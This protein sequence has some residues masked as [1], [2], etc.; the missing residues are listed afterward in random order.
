MLAANLE[1]RQIGEQFKL[2]DTASMPQRPY[3]QTQRLGIMSSGAIAGLILGL[4]VVGLGE[5]RDS[6]FRSEQE[7]LR[8]L[9][10]PVLGLIPAMRSGREA[11]AAKRRAR[12]IDA[13]GGALLV[14]AGL[15][16]V[17]WRMQS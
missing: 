13:A 3:N 4:L 8:V 9:S 11:Q 12:L 10:V 6:S 5:Y 17:I 15:V 1:R 16:L 14:A 7:A 2:L